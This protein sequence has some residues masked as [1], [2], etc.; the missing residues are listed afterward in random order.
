MAHTP[1][2]IGADG[3]GLSK[4][5]G[6]LSIAQLRDEDYEP[7]AISSLLAKIGTSDAVEA[8]RDLETLASEFEFAKIGR[9]P[10]RFDEK[11]LTNLN[12]E[13]V[14]ASSFTD[15]EAR[16]SAYTLGGRADETFWTAISGNLTRVSDAAEWLMIIYGDVTTTVD[17]EDAEYI[18]TAANAL[19]NGDVT[20]ATW[21]EWTSAL[22]AATG[23]KGKAL[24]M[25]LRLALT[26]KSQGPSMDKVLSLLGRDKA[27]TRLSSATSA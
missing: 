12:A 14:H 17:P 23:R 27:L 16:V 25:P 22:K 18:V 3:Q 10:A 21:G 19:P 5:L 6:S 20:D 8:R 15:V 1:L 7:M 13:L 24:F 26:G 11:D 9:A 2:L 4:R